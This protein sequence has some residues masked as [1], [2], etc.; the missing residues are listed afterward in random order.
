[1]NNFFP[2]YINKLKKG[3]ISICGKKIVIP[4]IN[5]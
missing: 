3:T 4:Y 1:M 5:D 2:P